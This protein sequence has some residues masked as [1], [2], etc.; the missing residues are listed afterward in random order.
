MDLVTFT[1]EIDTQILVAEALLTLEGGR[2]GCGW[3][4]G[5]KICQGAIPSG[6]RIS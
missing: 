5:V 4:D 3:G 1:T 2:V 6:L